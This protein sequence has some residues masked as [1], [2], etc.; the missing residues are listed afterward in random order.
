MLKNFLTTPKMQFATVFGA[1]IVLTAVSAVVSNSSNPEYAVS[2][3]LSHASSSGSVADLTAYKFKELLEKN[4]LGQMTVTIY[5]NNGLSGGDQ[6]R[7]V[8]MATEGAIDLQICS[9]SDLYNLDKRFGAFWLP[10]LFEND[11]QIEAFVKNPNV[12]EILDSWLNPY[13]LDLL[14]MYSLGGS[15]VSNNVKEIK[16]PEDLAG[17]KFAVP[18]YAAAE[19]GARILGVD[20]PVQK[21]S[22]EVP[23]ALEQGEIQGQFSS[24]GAY[25]ASKLYKTQPY[26]TLWNVYYDTQIWVSNDDN[27]EKLTPKQ[28]EII[29]KSALEAIEWGNNLSNEFNKLYLE[30]LSKNGVTV[31]SLTPEQIEAFQQKAVPLYEQRLDEIGKDTVLFFLNNRGLDA[32]ES[33]TL[34]PIEYP[35]LQTPAETAEPAPAEEAA[36]ATEEATA[37]AETTEPAAEPAPA[38]EAAPATEEAAAPAETT[39]PAPAET[40]EV[41]AEPAPAEEAA[42]AAEEAAA[43][44]ETAEVAAE[45]APA[46]EAAPAAE[47]AAAPAETTEV[48]AEPAAPAEEVAPAE[49]ATAP[50]ETTEVA[51]EPAAPAEEVAPAE[52]ATAPAERGYCCPC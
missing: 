25:V 44:A 39:E 47:E 11:E 51:A 46:E 14:S 45:P 38:E 35:E 8:E 31:T 48:A 2:L 24:L 52:E 19:E 7:A 10:F 23:L 30:D 43:P 17:I 12:Q 3:R 27:M 4:S 49:E 18:P 29:N 1:C 34:T 20:T 41:A 36:P 6:K 37:P 33:T 15:Q 50:A 13:N 28:R 42:P 40:A 22:S 21:D 5:P 9:A 16:A 32:D 26:V